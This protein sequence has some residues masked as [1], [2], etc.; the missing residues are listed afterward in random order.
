MIS[1]G[2]NV[3]QG[4]CLSK[5]VVKAPFNNGYPYLLWE[6]N[7]QAF[8]ETPP[9]GAYEINFLQDLDELRNELNDSSLRVS[10]LRN[11]DFN[12][13]DSYDQTDPDWET[14]KTA[15]TTGEGW[16][17]IG[18]GSGGGA[19]PLRGII[20]GNGF[21]I[22]NLFF[23]RTT[24]NNNSSLFGN[25]IGTI[26]DLRVHGSVVGVTQVG[27]FSVSNTTYNR[28]GGEGSVTESSGGAG[29]GSCI[30]SAGSGS[31]VTQCYAK[32][33]IIG[34]SN[35]LA[36][37]SGRDN[38]VT[39]SYGIG[40]HNATA[41]TANR[42]GALIGADSSATR[43]YSAVERIGLGDSFMATF[44]TSLSATSYVDEDVATVASV[45]ANNKTTAEMKDQATFVDWDFDTIWGID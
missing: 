37:L 24:T 31:T 12:D 27:L 34:D 16:I 2:G 40:S 4:F 25:F 23:N 45:R 15:W 22:F 5:A 33:N 6:L 39:D 35:F 14:K 32:G 38:T 21:K 10:L 11:L 17:G 43:S 29:A 9:S 44:S 13:N 7:P 3:F 1:G 19:N 18:F 42:I 30:L 41:G 8:A 20:Y 26:N 36:L 28:C